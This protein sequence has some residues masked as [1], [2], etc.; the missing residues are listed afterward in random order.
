[1]GIQ[2]FNNESS[3]Y[4]C[5]EQYSAIVESKYIFLFKIYNYLVSWT[6]NYVHKYNSIGDVRSLSFTSVINFQFFLLKCYQ[7][8][9]ILIQVSYSFYEILSCRLRWDLFPLNLELR[10]LQKYQ[11]FPLFKPMIILWGYFYFFCFDSIYYLY[12]FSMRT[13]V[14]GYFSIIVVAIKFTVR[15]LIITVIWVKIIHEFRF[16]VEWSC[17]F[18]VFLYILASLTTN[19]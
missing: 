16:T 6:T 15:T 11:H 1:M 3:T 18:E 10:T 2:H 19:L 8:L 17:K 13:V 9:L 14:F 4:R 5:I 7:F 12:S